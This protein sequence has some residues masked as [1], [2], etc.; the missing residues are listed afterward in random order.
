[1]SAERIT[2][3][4]VQVLSL[5]DAEGPLEL[6]P[7]QIVPGVSAAAQAPYRQRYPEAFDERGRWR[8]PFGSFLLRSG[9]RI[10]LVDTGIGPYPFALVGGVRGRLLDELRARSVDPAAIHTVF[11]THA[12]GDHI[13]WNVLE[14][15][16][17]GFP[18]ARYLIHRA[19]WEWAHHS[20][21]MAG[22]AAVARSLTPLEQLGRLELLDG[23]TRITDAIT[24]IHTPGHTPG[25][26]SVMIAS[27]GEK[28]L[29]TGDVLSNPAQISEPG[30]APIFDADGEQA[31]AT[32]RALIDRI[33]A[34]GMTIAAGHF[35]RPG[36]GRIVRLEG[37]R[38]WQAL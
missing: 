23:E 32:R 22:N 20:E 4:A 19:D 36:F 26:M 33:E 3:G 14:N 37:R 15:G 31:A 2:I 16:S 38:Y 7:E 21:R 30:W 5:A 24:A 29:I 10:V 8:A 18:T 35:P 27:R 17:A 28:A 6:P 34:E 11:L 12:H 9:G 1:M 25:H 13:G